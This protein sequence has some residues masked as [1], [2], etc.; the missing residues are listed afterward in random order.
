MSGGKW[1]A[2]EGQHKVCLLNINPTQPECHARP[3]ERAVLHGDK[4]KRPE[5][6][7]VA[8]PL[9]QRDAVKVLFVQHVWR[10]GV[11]GAV[12]RSGSPVLTLAY[13]MAISVSPY[14]HVQNGVHPGLAVVDPAEVPAAGGVGTSVLRLPIK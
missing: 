7:H 13:Q 3:S 2:E 6:Q 10:P 1:G 5:L 14:F 12:G 9:H 11:P 4:L 8:V